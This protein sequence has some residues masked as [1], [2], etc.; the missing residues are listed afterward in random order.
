MLKKLSPSEAVSTDGFSLRVRYMPHQ[1]E[2]EELGGYVLLIAH[3]F[4]RPNMIVYIDGARS[5]EPPHAGEAISESRKKD[6][7]RN[8]GSALDTLGIPFKCVRPATINVV[9]NRFESSEGY[10]VELI[11]NEQIRYSDSGRSITFAA[12][13]EGVAGLKIKWAGAARWDPPNAEAQLTTKEMS[14]VYQ[15]LMQAAARLGIAPLVLAR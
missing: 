15:R 4:G 3:D 9:G 2:Y 8:I 14:R 12:Q 6:I 13:R 10:S 7:E 1:L 5:W 11:S